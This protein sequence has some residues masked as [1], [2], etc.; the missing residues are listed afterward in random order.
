M[1]RF[2]FVSLVLFGL[3]TN[4]QAGE[5]TGRPYSP[6]LATGGTVVA[7]AGAAT[8]AAGVV[9]GVV[10]LAGPKKP[11]EPDMCVPGT[12]FC[13]FHLLGPPTPTPA[14][15]ASPGLA[16]VGIG[17]ATM[18]FGAFLVLAGVSRV[19]PVHTGANG[20]TYTF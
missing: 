1:R 3:A 15:D 13:G 2:A 20:I 19:A 7:A 16:M 12:Y 11:I 14:W 10:V 6:A 5:P 18:L 17:A 8:L 9:W 4:A